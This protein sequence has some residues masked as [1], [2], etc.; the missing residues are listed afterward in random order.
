[1]FE[2]TNLLAYTAQPNTPETDMQEFV[3]HIVEGTIDG[4]QVECK[5]NA[6][7]PMDAIEK[8]RKYPQLFKPKKKG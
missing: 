4:V 6:R 2:V 1:M 3:L 5:L 8:A 7:D